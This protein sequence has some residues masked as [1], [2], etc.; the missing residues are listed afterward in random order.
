M[1]MAE[2]SYL[3][4]GKVLMGAEEEPL[5]LDGMIRSLEIV[6]DYDRAVFPLLRLHTKLSYDL[7]YKIQQD[8]N[9]R[10]SLT[11]KKFTQSQVEKKDTTTYTYFIK[12]M[13]FIPLDKEKTPVNVPQDETLLPDTL[14][15]LNAT[16]LLL[17]EDDLRNNRGLVNTVLTSVD[18]ESSIMYLTKRFSSKPIIFEKPDNDRVYSQVIFPP[19]NLIRSIKYLDSIYGVYKKGLRLFFDLTGYYIM[20]KSDN[21]TTGKLDNHHKEVYITVHNDNRVATDSI[22]MDGKPTNPDGTPEN[23]YW[24]KVH[25]DDTRFIN[26]EDTK[27][28][29]VG[30]NNIVVS[31]GEDSLNRNIYSTSELK[32]RVY[33]NRY[34]NQFKENEYFVN[35][36][37][38]LFLVCTLD[39][40]DIDATSCN[41][42]FFLDYTNDNY[43]NH[44]GEY[45]ILK[46]VNSFYVNSAGFSSLQ[47]N[48]YLRKK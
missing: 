21:K 33:Y 14:P 17:C 38:G 34:N 29:F 41:K 6:S 5:L 16:F 24:A 39:G 43:K 28:E 2:Y 15:M 30:T 37:L 44:N 4:E 36:K 35:A 25:V 11:I 46:A 3:I 32:T 20:N 1:F 18:M 10:F 7:F 23:F 48:L 27:K 31:Q 47:S 22:L 45:H 42:Q 40:L 9:V 26:Y 8:D 19:N 12:D 13:V